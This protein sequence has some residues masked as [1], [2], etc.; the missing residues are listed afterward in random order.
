MAA[1]KKLHG[2]C[3]TAGL[4]RLPLIE[5]KTLRPRGYPDGAQFHPSRVGEGG[6][7]LLQCAPNAESRG[8]LHGADARREARTIAWSRRSREARRGLVHLRQE[9]PQGGVAFTASLQDAHRMAGG[10]STGFASQHPWL[11]SFRPPGT[12]TSATCRAGRPLRGAEAR[13]AYCFL[14]VSGR[15]IGVRAGSGEGRRGDIAAAR[16]RVGRV[17]QR[18]K[19]PVGIAEHL[20][21]EPARC[22]LRRGR[23][24]RWPGR[25]R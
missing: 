2:N 15:V 21:G 19:G 20:A 7:R 17:R 16:G 10:F 8:P 11:L 6:G 23:R 24:W 9:K 14:C 18:V 4:H 5:Q 1:R 22:R 3:Q 12:G 13:R 25:G